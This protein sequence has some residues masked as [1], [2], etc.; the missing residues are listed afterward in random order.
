MQHLAL[1]CERISVAL[2][3]RQDVRA[4]QVQPEPVGDQFD[5]RRPA[6]P[7]PRCRAY[8]TDEVAKLLIGRD[9]LSSFHIDILWLTIAAGNIPGH[10]W[11][12]TARDPVRRERPARAADEQADADSPV[13]RDVLDIQICGRDRASV[14][15]LTYNLTGNKKPTQW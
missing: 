4:W 10:P 3:G 15:R 14:R 13:R 2:L 5:R 7:V 1:V 9:Q 6:W 11:G 8:R 12:E